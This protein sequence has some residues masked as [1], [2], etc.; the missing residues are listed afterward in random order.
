MFSADVFP[1]KHVFPPKNG[2]VPS[3]PVNGYA[4]P[5]RMIP[6]EDGSR[7]AF[8]D[9]VSHPSALMAP[10]ESIRPSWQDFGGE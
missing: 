10:S 9:E 7:K 5:Q 8:R 4:D 2:P 3:R 1:A 6:R